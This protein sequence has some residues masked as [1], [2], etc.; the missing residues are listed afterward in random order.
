MDDATLE[1]ALAAID[2]IHRQ[3]PAGEELAYADSIERW[4]ARLV[5]GM[6]PLARLAARCQHLERWAL[7]RSGFPM[8]RPGYLQWRIAVHRRQ[9]ERA[10]EL[11]RAAGIDVETAGELRALVAKQRPQSG[12]GQALEDAACLVFLDEQ[13]ADFIASKDYDDDKVVAIVQKTWR[14]MSD[15]GH[16]LA[17]E[18]PL[19]GRLGELVQR[20][21]A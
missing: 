4:M 8:D 13:A 21:L 18:L 1:Q 2:A 20:A 10:E 17:L 15:R 19:S 9:G 7:P 6:T 3:D 11:V 12:L 14:K 5:D 16:A